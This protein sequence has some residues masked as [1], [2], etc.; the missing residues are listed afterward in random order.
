MTVK[1]AEDNVLCILSLAASCPDE[2]DLILSND[3][4]SV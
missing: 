2:I 1:V 4:Y 3:R